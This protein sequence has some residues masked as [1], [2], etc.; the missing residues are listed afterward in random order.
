MRFLESL[1]RKG[2]FTPWS[3]P[4]IMDVCNPYINRDRMYVPRHSIPSM[5]NCDFLGGAT[6]QCG[7]R[8][9]GGEG[10]EG[11]GGGGRAG[12]GRVG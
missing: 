2:H 5:C 12:E 3:N 1:L 11:G 8:E 10:E 9:E 6:T 4:Y 7:S